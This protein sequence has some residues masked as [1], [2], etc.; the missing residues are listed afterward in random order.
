MKIRKKLQKKPQR[1]VAAL[2]TPGAPELRFGREGSGYM[3]THV[4]LPEPHPL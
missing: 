3:L 2:R 4:S 1:P